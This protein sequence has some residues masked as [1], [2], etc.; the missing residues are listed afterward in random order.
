M[1]NKYILITNNLI[2]ASFPELKDKKI[3]LFVFRLRFYAMS[4]WLPPFIRFI[5][6][7]TRTKDFND[8]VLTGIIAHELCH[9]E[10]YAELG[11]IKYIRFAISFITSRKAQAAEERATDKLTIEKGYGR[12]L[13]ELSEIQYFDKKH[14]RIN[15]FYMSLEEIKS[16]AESIGKW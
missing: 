9:Q 15:E 12:Q 4:V 16:Y 3:N 1:K 13:Y 5:V 7:S 2:R 10:R 14:E 11:A 6:M 8:N